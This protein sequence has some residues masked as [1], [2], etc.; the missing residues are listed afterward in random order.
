MIETGIKALIIFDGYCGICNELISIVKKFDVSNSLLCIPS[1]SSK[2]KMHIKIPESLTDKSVYCITSHKKI[3]N[4][5]EAIF[6]IMSYLTGKIG[7]IGTV[8]LK[9]KIKFLAEPFY[10]IVSANRSYISK[11]FRFPECKRIS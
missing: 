1:Q 9:L 3:F 4:G 2:L 11:L 5:S 10:R 7:V 6:K 8:L